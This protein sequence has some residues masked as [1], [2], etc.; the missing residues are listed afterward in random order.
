[1][2]IQSNENLMPVKCILA[3][4][5]PVAYAAVCSKAVVLLLLTFCLLL[6]PLWESV[7]CFVVRY[8]IAIILM[9]KR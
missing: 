7:L 3:P 9:G 1:M 4:P 2:L 6:L 5:P 8:F